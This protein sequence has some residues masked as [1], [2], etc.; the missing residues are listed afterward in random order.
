MQPQ[1]PRYMMETVTS[2][3][4]QTT[5][6]PTEVTPTSTKGQPKDAQLD[7]ARKL[8]KSAKISQGQY[9][10]FVCGSPTEP[11]AFSPLTRARAPEY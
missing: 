3:T 4:K 8:K 6:H 2:R 10:I 9:K 11:Q 1:F 5:N 7:Q